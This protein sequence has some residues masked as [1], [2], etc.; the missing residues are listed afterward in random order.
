MARSAKEAELLNIGVLGAGPISQAAHFEGC[1][2]ARNARLYA[3]CE[4]APD[5]LESAAHTYRPA[6]IFRR[7]DAMLADP[8]VHAVII[9]V[10]DQF[11]VPLSL[12][13]LAAGKHVL[14]EKPMGVSVEEAESLR[15]AV[16]AGSLILQVGH[17]RRFDPGVA[18]ARLFVSQELGRMQSYQGWYY[19][20][21][22]RYIMTDNLQP[23]MRLSDSARRPAGDPKNDR[24][25]YLLLTH[26]SHLLDTARFLG[27]EII[28]VRARYNHS[29]D[30]HCWFIEI[31]FS[32]GALG[33]A[34]LTVP[35]RGDF[36][37]GFRIAGEFG[38]VRARLPLTWFHRCGDVECYSIKDGLYRRPLGADAFSYKLQIESFAD[39]LLHGKSQLGADVHD[40]VAN[41]RAMVA[42]AKSVTNGELLPLAS[43][44]G[45]P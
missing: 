8:A 10:A 11:H 17:N 43:V 29:F 2:K 13:A 39:V 6:K 23:L 16:A 38:S 32:N 14:V 37:E 18:F 4:L 26:G 40:G 19:D 25:R 20:S 22:D 24:Q 44:T 30:A 28:A 9:A 34:D 15:Q 5:L 7:F 3:I 41:I 36:E 33:H 42:V 35:L 31:H 1:Q 45:E 21:T 27:G 12:Q